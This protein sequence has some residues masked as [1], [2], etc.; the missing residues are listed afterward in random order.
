MRQETRH[1]PAAGDLKQERAIR[2]R[3][4]ILDAA[5]ETFANKGYPDTTMLDVA[6]LTGATKGAIY[7]HFANKNALAAA[8]ADEFYTRLSVLSEEVEGMGLPPCAA[9][10]ELLLRT[11]ALFRDNKIAQAGARLQLEHSL[12]EVPLPTPFVGFLTFISRLLHFA[13]ADG[14]LPEGADPDVLSRVLVSA[15]FGAQHMSWVLNDRQDVVDR[16]QE[17]LGAVLPTTASA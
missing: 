15:F 10:A 8:V 9:V 13:E 5:A 1:T 4:L 17:I 3:A 2:T 16:V 11:G 7:F 6:Q 12:I 14:D